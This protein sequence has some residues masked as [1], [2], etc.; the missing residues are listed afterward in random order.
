M[1]TRNFEAVLWTAAGTALFTLVFASGK[2]A[3]DSAS[4][5]QIL[6]LRYVGGLATLGAVVAAT[7]QP[8]QRLVS[9]RPRSHLLRATLGASGGMAAIQAA[10]GMPIVDATAIGLLQVV[11]AIG[12]GVW[13]LG[14][15]IGSRQW[16]GIVL[17]TAGA[18]TIVASKGAFRDLDAAYVLPA[19]IAAAGALLVAGETIMIK[20][21]SVREPALTVLLYVNAFG[22]AILAAPAW[23]AWR[24]LGLT[25][26]WP[27][28]ML[29]PIAITAQ[30]CIIR[31]YRL[32]DVA[33][34]GPV[35]YSWLV[36]AGILGLV[37]FGEVPGPASYAG[38]ALILAGGLVLAR[39]RR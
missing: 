36:F 33:L 25:G 20:T 13:L 37:F 2:F 12:L 34:L 15:R 39:V 27:F 17:C 32:A 6:W 21:L 14:E 26:L 7:R 38:A 35:D 16:S 24:P 10:A 30:F 22:I 31:G 1:C 19:A 28:V 3:G 4:A 5:P 23:L 29:G 11:F 18:A 8:P 9:R